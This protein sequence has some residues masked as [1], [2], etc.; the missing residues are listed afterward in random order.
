MLGQVSSMGRR[1]CSIMQ[2]P[3]QK[4]PL[5][6]HHQWNLWVRSLS[7]HNRYKNETNFF[8]WELLQKQNLN[9]LSSVFSKILVRKVWTLALQHSS[10]YFP[11]WCAICSVPFSVWASVDVQTCTAVLWLP[12]YFRLTWGS[13]ST[14]DACLFFPFLSVMCSCRMWRSVCTTAK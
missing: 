6:S 12:G 8:F 5:L 2:M 13:P 10:P 9:K 3:W 4:S 7:V 1:R 11:S 14:G